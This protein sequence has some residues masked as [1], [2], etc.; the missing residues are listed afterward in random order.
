M[1]KGEGVWGE[2]LTGEEICEGERGDKDWLYGMGLEGK[3]LCVLSDELKSREREK[4]VVLGVG[5][6]RIG[7]S[8]YKRWSV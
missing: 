5:K 4:F 8:A 1:D 3:V 6:G 7:G 2:S